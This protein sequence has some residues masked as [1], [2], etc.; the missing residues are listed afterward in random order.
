MTFGRNVLLTLV[1]ALVCNIATAQKFSPAFMGFSKKKI[2]YIHMKDG[3]VKEG[4]LK[5]LSYKKAL[6]EEVKIYLKKKIYAL[7]E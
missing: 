7:N 1:V 4:Y 6:I 3:S 5:K 2:S